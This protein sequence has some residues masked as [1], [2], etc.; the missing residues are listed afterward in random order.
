MNQT[1]ISDKIKRINNKIKQ[2]EVDE[3][4]LY[5]SLKTLFFFWSQKN[6][7]LGLYSNYGEELGMLAKP[8]KIKQ[9]QQK[10]HAGMANPLQKVSIKDSLNSFDYDNPFGVQEL[11]QL[12]SGLMN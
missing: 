10:I 6:E 2:L 4:K 12:Y 8:Q 11:K 9:I 1:A 3:P 5:E 7:K